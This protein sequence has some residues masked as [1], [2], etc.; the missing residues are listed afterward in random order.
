MGSRARKVVDSI[1]RQQSVRTAAI[2]L[3]GSTLLASLLGFL[4]DRLLNGY[5]L[6]TYPAGIDAYTVAFIIPDFM[7]SILASGALTVTFIPVFN[8]LRGDKR[9]K[10]N[11]LAWELASSMINC[12]SLV[13]LLLSIGIMVF[14]DPLIRYVVGPGLSESS[15]A[16]AVSL[17]RVIAINPFLFSISGIL[18]SIQQSFGRYIFY[19]L[20]PAMYNIGIVIGILGFTNGI[21]IFGHTIFEGGIMGVALGVVFGAILQV[22]VASIGI[23]GLGFDYKFRIS[24]QNRG[25]RKVLKIF[26]ARSLDQGMDYINSLVETRLASG[27]SSGTIRA[28]NQAL[29]LHYMPVNLIGVAISNA[30]FASMTEKLGL[31]QTGQFRR[32]VQT[33]LRAIIW[34]ATPV[35][36][37]AYFT[38]GYL[39]NFIKNGGNLLMS[40]LLG[41]LVLAIL[42][43]SIYHILA[44]TFYA[45]QNTKIP[46]YVSI[47]AV[48]VNIVLAVFFIHFWK[49]GAAGLAWAQAIAAIFETVVLGWFL[50]RS[51]PGVFDNS[52][53]TAILGILAASGTTALISY[54]MVINFPLMGTDQSFWATFPKFCLI[55]VVPMIGYLLMSKLFHL[56]EADVIL[57]RFYKIL[58]KPENKGKV[59]KK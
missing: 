57:N 28:Y 2:V 25:F 59:N 19:A 38:R 24:W 53:W 39:V 31:G 22:V 35:T 48:I 7:F 55:G 20:A 44:R 50:A 29:T 51:V 16:L 17:M 5:Y 45:Q 36:V 56:R 8:Q 13:T 1:N 4:R 11:S 3:A 40:N 58:F 21:T 41:Y 23:L 46:L 9:S 14:A 15:R 54:G 42:F 49:S 26:P 30:A 27:M 34:I 6:E 52:F 12:M 37:I 32:E 33:V 10:D 18:S 43:R 47:A